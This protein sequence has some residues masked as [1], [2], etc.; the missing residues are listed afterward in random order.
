M[1]PIEAARKAIELREKATQGRWHWWTS[2]SWRRLR[3]ET[4]SGS[5]VSVMEPYISRSD[6]HPDIVV[7]EEDMA[8]SEHAANTYAAVAEA[9]IEAMK[10]IEKLERYI[11]EYPAMIAE[12]ERD[13]E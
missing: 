9:L 12:E 8:F 10:R 11:E 6:R 3:A 1:T 7:S 5:T 4:A 13:R 2:N